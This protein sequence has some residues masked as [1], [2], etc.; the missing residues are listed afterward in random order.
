MSLEKPWKKEFN[1][2][3]NEMQARWGGEVS[4]AE[5][6]GAEIFTYPSFY[7]TINEFPVMISISEVGFPVGQSMDACDNIEYLMVYLKTPCEFKVA[8]RHET[9]VDRLKKKIGFEFEFQTS[10]DEF[11]KDYF[12]VTQDFEQTDRIK[13]VEFQNGIKDLEP[14]SGVMAYKTGIKL[15]SQINDGSDLLLYKVEEIINRLISLSKIM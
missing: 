10:N 14:F 5:E 8:I 4:E 11:D 1:E 13:T 2:L 7:A 9:F 3:L 6:V 12:I 15:T